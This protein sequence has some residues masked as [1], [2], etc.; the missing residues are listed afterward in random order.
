MRLLAAV[1]AISVAGSPYLQ[2]A[3]EM[4]LG[5]VR[6]SRSAMLDG[7]LGG[8]LIIMP[9]LERWDGCLPADFAGEDW[10]NSG[11]EEGTAEPLAALDPLG[12]ACDGCIG[13]EDCDL[14]EEWPLRREDGVEDML[15]VVKNPP[16]GLRGGTKLWR[17]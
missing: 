8:E 15:G 11:E 3:A 10:K 1:T 12:V 4:A 16:Q 2:A 9:S 6:A 7:C 13:V 5:V 17:V 14:R